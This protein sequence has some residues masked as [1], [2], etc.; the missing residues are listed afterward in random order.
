MGSCD[1]ANSCNPPPTGSL[2]M[3]ADLPENK[4][5]AASKGASRNNRRLGCCIGEVRQVALASADL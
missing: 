4:G 1:S 3:H 2:Q 5:F